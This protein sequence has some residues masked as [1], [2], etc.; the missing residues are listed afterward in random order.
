MGA[1]FPCP[2]RDEMLVENAG[3][4]NAVPLGTEC[5]DFSS[6]LNCNH[7]ASH[8]GR[9]IF[10]TLFSTNIL[11][12]TGQEHQQLITDHHLHNLV[13][14]ELCVV[15]IESAAIHRRLRT[16]CPMRGYGKYSPAKFQYRCS[17]KN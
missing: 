16:S 6:G 13:L 14:A 8:T 4:K 11:S 7:I 1:D 17:Q 3:L 15:G 10:L 5:D 12:L 9:K 2:D